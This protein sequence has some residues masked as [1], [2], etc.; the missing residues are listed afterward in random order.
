MKRTNTYPAIPDFSDLDRLF[1]LAAPAFGRLGHFFE[2]RARV[3]APAA[4]FFEDDANYYVKAELPG[5]RKGDVSVE[6]DKGV[7]SVSATRRQKKGDTEHSF[8]YRRSLSIPDGVQTQD[9]QAR[10]ED[11]ILTLTLPKAPQAK[12]RQIKIK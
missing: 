10:H 2:D 1:D 7:L 9:I 6:F 5:V 3:S 11:G 12:A 4:D 8:E